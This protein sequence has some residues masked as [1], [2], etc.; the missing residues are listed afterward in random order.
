M[1]GGEVGEKGG[2]AIYIF[3]HNHYFYLMLSLTEISCLNTPLF[4]EDSRI[5]KT[6]PVEEFPLRNMLSAIQG[7]MI[8]PNKNK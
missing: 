6:C 2:E 5:K 3:F 4:C 8:T 1:G 7:D